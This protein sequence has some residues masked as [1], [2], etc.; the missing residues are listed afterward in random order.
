MTV[1]RGLPAH[2]GAETAGKGRDQSRWTPLVSRAPPP[3]PGTV[4]VRGKFCCR[5]QKCEYFSAQVLPQ[6]SPSAPSP[7]L[8]PRT[9]RLHCS[10]AR[11][12]SSFPSRSSLLLVSCN[13][14]FPMNKPN[15]KLKPG[16]PTYGKAPRVSA[17]CQ[18][19]YTAAIISLAPT[20]CFCC[21]QLL[22]TKAVTHAKESGSNNL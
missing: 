8:Q 15:T 6:F 21:Q 10:P 9:R 17:W 16:A 7:C 5:C 19:V 13:L 22:G 18:R 4:S 11:Q 20:L 2:P 14:L 12:A 3:P 1:G